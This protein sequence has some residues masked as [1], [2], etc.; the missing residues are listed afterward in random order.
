MTVSRT[1]IAALALTLTAAD[2]AEAG[3]ACRYRQ[4]A[5]YHYNFAAPIFP[6][7]YAPFAA[8]YGLDFRY[9]YAW[10]PYLGDPRSGYYFSLPEPSAPPA[11]YGPW[12]TQPGP[13]FYFYYRK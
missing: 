7:P 4:I 8:G 3:V 9:G 13:G 11:A 1:L 12:Y 10:P 6:S 5:P 2:A